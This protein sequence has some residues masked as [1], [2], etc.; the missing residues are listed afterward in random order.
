MTTRP[1]AGEIVAI[2]TT[3]SEPLLLVCR[4]TDEHVT[5]ILLADLAT[6][7]LQRLRASEPDTAT[8]Q[9][10]AQAI[11]RTNELLSFTVPLTECAL[12]ERDSSRP[13]PFEGGDA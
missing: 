8:R 3:D 11:G 4:Q 6:E 12:V 10:L 7:T 2:T 13:D 9:Q 5:G 1:T